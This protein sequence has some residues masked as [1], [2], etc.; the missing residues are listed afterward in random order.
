MLAHDVSHATVSITIA[1]LRTCAAG[2]LASV[3]TISFDALVEA[4]W[5]PTRSEQASV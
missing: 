1:D 4:R 5:S 2:I 3:T